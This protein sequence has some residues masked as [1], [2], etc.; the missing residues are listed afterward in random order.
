MLS[1]PS[2]RFSGKLYPNGEFGVSRLKE[3]PS[4]PPRRDFL[5]GAFSLNV[6]RIVKT[7]GI[8]MAIFLM[9]E[10]LKAKPTLTS[11]NVANSHSSPE[12]VRRGLRGLT[13]HGGRLLRNA[14]FLLEGDC[15][16]KLTSFLTVTIPPITVEESFVIGE[17]WADLTKVLHQRIRRHLAAAGLPG[18]IFGCTEIQGDRFDSSGIVALHLHWVFQGRHRGTTWAITPLEVSEW[19]RGQLENLLGRRLLYPPR[20]EMTPV[21]KSVQGYIAKYVSKGGLYIQTYIDQGHSRAIPSS[22]YLI[23]EK[24]R[25]RIKQGTVQSY[26]LAE[27]IVSLCDR[28]VDGVFVWMK[29]IGI[30]MADGY[31]L[32]VG[33][34]GRLCTD[35]KDVLT[36]MYKD[37]RLAIQLQTQAVC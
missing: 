8:E 25:N 12:S 17:A 21:Q 36:S 37:D 26:S 3:M 34:A 15:E 7:L 6:Q 22:W 24:M 11:S 32:T 13:R 29:K 18:E 27:N 30:Q 1:K 14:A 20:V 9:E 31:T 10:G 35:V 4:E 33:Y 19:W 16:R 28:A 23:S 2:V 5:R